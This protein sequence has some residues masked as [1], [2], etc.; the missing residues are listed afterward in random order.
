MS[1]ESTRL[2]T[3]IA[4]R[5][6][7]AGDDVIALRY[8]TGL[9]L[10]LPQPTRADADAIVAT[11][12]AALRE[13]SIDDITIF[14]DHVRRAW[15]DPSNRWRQLAIELGSQVTGYARA[16]VESDVNY[17]GHTLERAKQY[18]FIETDLG[19]PALLDEWQPSKAIMRRCWPKGL[20]AHVMVGNVPLASLFTLYRSLVTKNVT[21]TK[22]PSR[23]PVAALCFANCIHDV[24]PDHPVTR[25]LS[26]LYWEPGSEVEE[27]VLDEAD[28]ISVWGRGETVEA[29]KR[30]VRQGVEVIEFGPK[31]SFALVLDGASAADR[32]ALKLA[33][34][35]VSY[36]QEGCFS[37]QEVYADAACAGEVA[38]QLAR[39]L[40][41]YERV[42]PRR[43]L[44]D[45]AAAHIQR[46]R[47]EAVAEGWDVLAPEDT[48]W[49][50]VVSDGHARIDEH[51][52]ARFLY[53]HPI[54]DPENAIATI[55]RNVQTVSLEPWARVE[56]LR[57]RITAAGADRIVPIGRMTR[58]RPG[59]I[60]DGFYPMR[61][62]VRWVSVER[63]IR[64]KYRFTDVSPDEYDER[65]YGRI[66][67]IAEEERE[68]AGAPTG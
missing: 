43:S 40:P 11:D 66:V 32:L 65:L 59:F 54:E 9:E 34:D 27:I 6:V 25:A 38:S 16:T 21:V 30:R 3:V 33:Y 20:I 24:D 60:H 47:L 64:H 48:T 39:W 5:R 50:V 42:L 36:D 31:R 46:A 12:R 68:T 67:R 41:F 37:L 44:S 28:V 58:F 23:D 2:P 15:M 29:L 13:T 17:L 57:D 61:Q 63:D 56:G 51:P 35:V 45:D 14:F 4:G 1:G 10:L 26:T 49:T 19:D 8:D 62:M 52:L 7:E 55:D 22:L 53:V 18:D